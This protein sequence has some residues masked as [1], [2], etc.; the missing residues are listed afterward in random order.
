M[1]SKAYQEIHQTG[2]EA[3]NEDPSRG[4]EDW[5]D[6][7]MRDNNASDGEGQYGEYDDDEYDD[8]SKL[9][10]VAHIVCPTSS[11]PT[12]SFPVP[13]SVPYSRPYTLRS[14]CSI[15]VSDP[16]QANINTI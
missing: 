8:I 10:S 12:S 15:S 14:R 2:S 9:L 6:G 13:G 5:V 4:D 7:E 11:C 16:F 1:L 3:P